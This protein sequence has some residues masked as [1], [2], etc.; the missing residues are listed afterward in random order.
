VGKH[1]CP[2]LAREG[3]AQHRV[4]R[5]GPG[6]LASH[7]RRVWPNGSNCFERPVRAALAHHFDDPLPELRRV[8]FPQRGTM[9]R[10]RINFTT[11]HPPTAFCLPLDLDD[12]VAALYRR[13]TCNSNLHQ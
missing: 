6:A 7:L 2:E 3:V 4:W 8:D 5:H 1:S 13:A 12:P 9:S 11:T 10:R